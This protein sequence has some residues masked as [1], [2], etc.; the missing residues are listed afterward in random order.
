MIFCFA[1]L[2]TAY[3]VNPRSPPPSS[4]DTMPPANKR[5]LAS[6]RSSQLAA[7]AKKRRTSEMPESGPLAVELAET[8]SGSESEG[9]LS[10]EEDQH[11][12]FVSQPVVGWEQAERGLPGYSKTR[13]YRQKTDYHKNKE[14][15]RRRRQDKQAHEAGI[16]VTQKA[17]PIWGD[18]S[19]M[20]NPKPTQTRSPSPPSSAV[21]PVTLPPL[22]SLLELPADWAAPFLMVD[23]W[24]AATHDSAVHNLTVQDSAA[25]GNS[26]NPG[27]GPSLVRPYIAP[28]FEDAFLSHKSF[29]EEARDL[30]IWLKKQKGKVTGDWLVR[31][32]CV[33]DLLEMQFKNIYQDQN[34]KRKDWIGFSEALARRVKRSDKWAASLRQWERNWFETRT[35]P[36]CPRRGRHIKRKSLFDDEGVALAVREY[37]NTA[38]WH[39]SAQGVC[40]AVATHL[41]SQ[42]AAVDVMQI[43]A[44]LRNGNKGRQG[45]SERT[46]NRWFLKL[47]WLWGRN[48]KG[49]CDGHER[50][51]VVEYRE[52]VFCPR[53]KVRGNIASFPAA[54]TIVDW[55]DSLS[56]PTRI[57]RLR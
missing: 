26:Q 12:A 17:K 53:M 39:A 22:S 14:E 4:V 48:K 18:I 45:I 54:L 11:P 35:P 13:N 10:E 56:N 36:P 33:K 9:L 6:Q 46:A 21:L 38:M 41:Q 44:V 28:G 55:I 49:Y 27:A 16:P 40:D 51:D 24:S 29:K 25:C 7:A 43:D 42:N 2:P 57:R 34:G 20:F 5:K 52:M 31:V 32:Q 30:D 50:A 15:H 3:P 1:R 37:L 19:K 23:P 8:S 47:G